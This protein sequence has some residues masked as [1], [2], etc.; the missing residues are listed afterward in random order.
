MKKRRW[1]FRAFGVFLAIVAV[2]I[3][4]AIVLNS[5]AAESLPFS[6]ALRSKLTADYSQDGKQSVLGALR[7]S[8]IGDALRDLGLTPKE[9]DQQ[10]AGIK[11]ALDD[12]V[13]TATALNF[14][15]DDPYTPTPTSTLTPTVTNT[16][17]NTPTSTP[18]PTKTPIP[19]STK[20]P[21]TAVPAG[22]TVS[23]VIADPGVISPIPTGFAS[24]NAVLT[25]V[26]ARITDA[27]LSSGIKY[28]KLKYK[29]FN[30]NESTIY[31]GYIYSAP[32]SLSSGGPTGGGW[33]GCYDGSMTITIS[34][35]F[36]ALSDYP[37]PGPFRIKVWLIT[38]DNVGKT[39]SY[40]F[41]D[42]TMPQNCDDPPAPT[43]T[44]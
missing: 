23:P 6:L 7:L 39:A 36:S 2:A 27:A 32:F 18:L 33:D 28:V 25:V 12:P 1:M 35:G 17:T 34:P 41:G 11:I 21:A 42:Y 9:A 4:A 14:D 8:I 3:S 5:A 19:T 44:P 29:V 24:C 38:E 30:D 22:D 13:P 20:K 16:P 26:N 10:T 43:P 15:G 37:G 40:F 31:A